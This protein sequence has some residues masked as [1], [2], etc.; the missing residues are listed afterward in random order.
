MNVLIQCLGHRADVSFPSLVFLRPSSHFYCKPES[1]F[2]KSNTQSP[3]TNY[4]YISS[5]LQFLKKCS[6]KKIYFQGFSPDFCM[7][8]AK[9]LCNS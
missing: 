7:E 2:Q 6:H 8:L 1:S 3:N 9:T 5:C 4:K